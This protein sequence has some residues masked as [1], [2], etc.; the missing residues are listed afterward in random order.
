MEFELY[1]TPHTVGHLIHSLFAPGP[2][3]SGE[4]IGPGA[5]RLGTGHLIKKITPELTP[6]LTPD[7]TPELTPEITPNY[8]N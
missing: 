3:R 6:F 5:K 8:V 4:R 1:S 2:I 7:L